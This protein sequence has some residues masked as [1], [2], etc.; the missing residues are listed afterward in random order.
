MFNKNTKNGADNWPHKIFQREKKKTESWAETWI[1]CWSQQQQNKTDSGPETG[2][3]IPYNRR[4]EGDESPLHPQNT[5]SSENRGLWGYEAH[6]SCRGRL[7]RLSVMGVKQLCQDLA[8][9]TSSPNKMRQIRQAENVYL[10]PT[11]NR[12]HL[13]HSLKYKINVHTFLPRKQWAVMSEMS[14]SKMELMCIKISRLVVTVN[15]HTYTK[16]I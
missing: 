6:L 1:G 16:G 2:K 5:R 12:R 14:I 11:A 15:I 4:N 7:S 9:K 10:I 13:R 8:F 3:I